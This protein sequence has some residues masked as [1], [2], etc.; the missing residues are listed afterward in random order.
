MFYPRL[1]LFLG[2]IAENYG[3][4]SLE[5]VSTVSM[6]EMANISPLEPISTDIVTVIGVS[7][8]TSAPRKEGTSSS[9]TTGDIQSLL[10]GTAA[11][12]T[13]TNAISEALT[14]EPGITQSRNGVSVQPTSLFSRRFTTSGLSTSNTA[15]TQTLRPTRFSSSTDLHF[16]TTQRPVSST[17][18]ILSTIQP[19]TLATT[20][21][22]YTVSESSP[23]FTSSRVSESSPTFTSSRVSESSPTF[24]S[25]RVSESS[26]TFTSSRVSES[27][28]TFTSSRVSESSPTFTSS[29]VS[30]SPDTALSNPTSP[31]PH[32]K[33]ISSIV[34]VIVILIFAIVVA[35]GVVFCIMRRKQRHSQTF[36]PQRK[37]AAK[38]EDAWAGPVALPEEGGAIDGTEEKAEEDKAAK[39]MSLSTFFGKR[40]SRAV[41]VLLEEVDV[42]RDAKD[43]AQGV[44]QPLL[45]KEPNGQVIGSQSPEGDQASTTGQSSGCPVSQESSDQKLLLPP[46][47]SPSQPNGEMKHESCNDLPPPPPL[48]DVALPPPEIGSGEGEKLDSFSVKTS[49]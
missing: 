38:A 32:S 15:T 35:G 42:V 4:V 39:R 34:I 48:N 29:R 26:P 20:S 3:L 24:T 37:K 12:L 5:M 17:N 30:E 27:S 23:T 2:V 21:N 22:P 6:D 10:V 13:T 7:E 46:P 18:L 47:P 14:G 33:S 19:V 41:S 31:L 44:Q 45:F 9:A 40:K 28:P 43:A 16:S 1:F 36:D 11:E 49:L 25:S 8:V